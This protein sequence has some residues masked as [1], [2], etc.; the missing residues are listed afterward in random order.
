MKGSVLTTRTWV[1]LL[2]TALLVA[3]GALNFAQRQT[4][5]PPLTDGV[6][7][8]QT[9]T[10]IYGRAIGLTPPA[11]PSAYTVSSPTRLSDCLAL[12]T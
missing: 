3:A 8:K 9:P 12:G 4:H 6:V 1:L 10:G 2:A 5:K 7:W 11:H